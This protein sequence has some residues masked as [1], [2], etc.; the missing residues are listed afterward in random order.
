MP[1]R[2][3]ARIL[4]RSASEGA[5][6]CMTEDR[7]LPKSIGDGLDADARSAAPW[8]LRNSMASV[9]PLLCLSAAAGLQDS[10]ITY[11][12]AA[13]LQAST[14]TL[15]ADDQTVA[16]PHVWSKCLGSGHAAL[17]LREDWRSHVRMARRDLGVEKVRFHGILNDEMS[18]SLGPGVNSFFNLDSVVDF[19]RSQGMRAVW[20]VTRAEARTHDCR[21]DL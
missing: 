16:L 2:M 7:A 15:N 9:A 6:G 20:E 11:N 18:T 13:G 12:A 10:T 21:P 5:M 4:S 17:T 14:I 3:Q 8:L 1:A 19:L